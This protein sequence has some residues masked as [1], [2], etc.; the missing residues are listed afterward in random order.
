MSSAAQIATLAL[1]LVGYPGAQPTQTEW[2]L[3]PSLTAPFVGTNAEYRVTSDGTVELRG[4]ITRVGVGAG[5]MFTLGAALAPPTRARNFSPH[6]TSNA[7]VLPDASIQ[8]APT[9]GTV[10]LVTPTAGAG[11]MVAYLDGISWS[12]N[13]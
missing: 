8:V 2:A 12:I 6:V 4:F 1:S 9:T 7:V 5:I 3:V 13:G 10:T 11:D